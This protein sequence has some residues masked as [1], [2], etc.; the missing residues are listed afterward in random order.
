MKK[1]TGL[2]LAVIMTLVLFTGCSRPTTSQTSDGPIVFRYGIRNAWMD[3][4]SPYTSAWAISSRTYHHNHYEGLMRLDPKLE[5]A[6]RLAESWTVSADG[7]TWTF[8]LRRGVKWHDGQDFNADDVVF[9]YKAVLENQLYRYFAEVR[10]IT[11]VTK[12][13]DYTVNIVTRVPRADYINMFVMEIVP[14]HIWNVNVT[15]EDFDAYYDPKM[16]GT[17]PW[18]FVE[19]SIDEFV[20]YRANDN[21]W[22]GR[23]KVDEFIYVFFANDDTKLQALEA[24][25]IDMT[26]LLASQV[27]YASRLPGIS[28]IEA[29]GLRLTELGFNMWQDR[30][31]RGNPL[32]RDEKRIRQ[33]ID[34][35]INYEELIAFAKGGLANMEYGLIPSLAK[36]FAWTPDN[37]TKREFSPQKAIALLESAGFRNVDANGIRSNAAGQR[38]DFRVSCIESSYRDAA[39]LIQRYCR[40]I[41]INM[42]I[43]YVDTGRQ[44]DIIENQDFDTDMYYWGWTGDYEDPGFILSVMT[45]D[46]IGGR[47]DCWYSNPEYDRLFNAQSSIMDLNERIAAVH[48]M[49]EI[50]YEDAPYLILYTDKTVTA[51]NSDKWTNLVRMPDLFGD[52][53]NQFSYKSVTRK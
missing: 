25:L 2:L 36:P 27:D 33:A 22:G 50:I 35:A 4:K 37:N 10:D 15:K 30:R 21:Y 29:G 32:I 41:G 42:E 40:D 1:I 5:H 13:N 39:L 51:Y 26:G 18:M 31:S 16:I 47:S 11:D 12:V 3:S 19:E 9:S 7:R 23:P 24:G 52:P 20:R 38:L 6:P 28:L 45:S 43:T 44:G 53:L 34:H 48:R 17:G 8:N 14:E 49:Q 46:Q